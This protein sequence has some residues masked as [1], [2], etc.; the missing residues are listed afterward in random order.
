MGELTFNQILKKLELSLRSGQMHDSIKYLS[1][2]VEEAETER[3]EAL[4]DELGDI[5]ESG[6]EEALED[7]F[8][9]AYGA[10]A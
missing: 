7:F 5:I 9:E 2:L 3:E 6:D 1:M 8:E 4:V 10:E